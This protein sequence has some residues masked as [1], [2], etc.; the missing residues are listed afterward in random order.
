MIIWSGWG[1][2]VAVLVF[3]LSLATELGV[4]SYFGDDRYYQTHAWP[5]AAALLV[6][7]AVTWLWGSRLNRGPGRTVI[8]KQTG[9]EEVIGGPGR[10]RLFFVPM[11]YWGPILAVGALVSLILR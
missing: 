8:D 2:M 1:F 5:L 9:R 10:H 3:A 7:A 4:E 6:A 11:Q